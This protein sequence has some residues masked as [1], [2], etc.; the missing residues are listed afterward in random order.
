[1][2]NR[3]YVGA[4]DRCAGGGY[5]RAKEGGEGRGEKIGG[6]KAGRFGCFKNLY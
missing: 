5:T 4:H 2:Q 1:M 3:A 6:E